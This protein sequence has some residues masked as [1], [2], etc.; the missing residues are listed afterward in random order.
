M[1]RQATPHT[2]GPWTEPCGPG[3]PDTAHFD[4]QLF[5]SGRQGLQHSSLCGVPDDQHGR[6][7]VAAFSAKWKHNNLF[8][9]L[10]DTWYNSLQAKVTKR[11]SHGLDL[12]YAFT[13]SKSE[14]LGAESEAIGPGGGV[15]ASVTDVMNRSI[16]KTLSGYDQPFVSSISFNYRTPR[17]PGNKLLGAVTSGWVIG[18]YLNYASGLPIIPQ[19]QNNLAS[20]L[21]GIAGN[22]ADRVPGVPL[23]TVP[24]LNCHCY[25]P[26]NTFV[27]EPGSVGA[28]ASR[29]V[30]HCRALLHGLPLQAHAQRERVHCT[31]I[32]IRERVSIQVRA[33]WLNIFNRLAMPLP[34]STNALGDTSFGPRLAQRNPG[35]ARSLHRRAR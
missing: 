5:D 15:A 32:R 23:F 34:I 4:P 16:N 25:D 31:H 26:A 29:A 21:P 28:A 11:L 14:T 6:A 19:S 3:R 13:W 18:S 27:P 33:E 17:A 20:V 12:T 24:D 8:A 1:A 7:G 35:L 2:C 22:N 9:P 10:G 30:W